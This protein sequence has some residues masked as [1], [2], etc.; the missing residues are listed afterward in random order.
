MKTKTILTTFLTLAAFSTALA[1]EVKVT[2]NAVSPTMTLTSKS[3]GDNI[4]TGSPQ[5]RAY[6]FNAPDGSYTLT[7]YGTDGTTVNGNIDIEINGSNTQFSVLT[8]TAYCTNRNA[9]NT[10]WSVAD[11]DYTFRVE[12]TTRDGEKVVQT[13]GNSVTAG[14]NTFLALNG[15]SYYAEFIPSK[16][17]SDE[18]YLTMTKG[19]TLTYNATVS[20]AMVKAAEV[21]VT[22]PEYAEIQLGTKKAHYVDFIIAEPS[23]T[24]TKN[25]SKVITYR[26]PENSVYNYRTWKE[27]GLT[28]GGYFTVS[29]DPAKQPDLTFTSEMYAT[30]NPKT[31][32]HDVNSNQGYETGDIFVN[33]NE[34]G[35]KDMNVGDVFKAHAMRT[36]ELTDNSTNNYFIEP[37]FHYTVVGLD[38]KP[39]TGVINVSQKPG[40]A[41]ADITAVGNGTAII[42]VTYDA[43][44]LNYFTSDG[45]KNEYLGGEFW[46][47]IW[48]ENTAAYVITVGQGESAAKP[49]MTIN[50]KYNLDTMKDAGKYV[51]A[52]HDVFYYLDTEEGYPYTFTAEGVADISIAYP[53]IGE[54]AAS[55]SGFG[56]E[57]AT[58]NG[59]G[60]YTVLL[61][62]GRQI[63]RLTDAAGKS[64]YQ[65]L[66]AKT[67]SREISN[68]TRPGSRIFQPGDEIKIQ[69]SGLRH[70]A[71][72]LAGIYNMSAYVTYNGIPNGTSLVLGKN[73][74]TF[75][76]AASA[77]AVKVTVPAD[78]D[79]TA[80][81]TFDLTEG[82]IQVNGYGDP[83]GNHRLINPETG[84]NANFTAVAHKTYFSAIPAVSIPLTAVRNFNIE[85]V[86]DTEGADIE[87]L[88]R[89]NPLQPG[90]DGLY[91]GTYGT[92][93]VVASKA[94]YRCFRHDYEI[95]ED[96]T[97]DLQKFDIAMVEAPGA[98]DGTTTKEPV[99]N[100][101]GFYIIESPEELAWYAAYVNEGNTASNA[102]LDSDIDLGDYL[103]TPVGTSSKNFAGTFNGCGHKV[104]GL[105]VNVSSNNAGLFGAVRGTAAAP[106]KITGITVYGSVKGTGYVGGIAG[107]LNDYASVDTCANYASVSGSDNF[108][109]GIAGR[110]YQANTS[111][112]NCYNAGQISSSGYHAGILGGYMNGRDHITNVFNVGEIEDNANAAAIS[113]MSG[114]KDNT[115]NAF[116][117]KDYAGT[118][119]YTVVTEQQMKSGEIAYKLGDAFGQKIGVDPYPVFGA[120]KVLYNEAEKLYYNEGGSSAIDSITDGTDGNAEPEVYYN[121]QGVK[122]E[123]PW[124]GINIVKMK[125]GSVRKVI[126][127]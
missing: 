64:T 123:T 30:R 98:W 78:L 86:C 88:Y 24:E 7:A 3:S 6:T 40:S 28:H 26:L 32:N 95:T 25:G 90:S 99:Q 46:G 29:S 45:K 47:A 21:T 4:E 63:V 53:T 108:V 18:G 85:L 5:S 34:R 93:T 52:E 51:D 49:E 37:D 57:G 73:Q 97:A 115:K 23:A 38:G 118:Q 48:P 122:S 76:S 56:S 27:G 101:A 19:G 82:V 13:P 94:G 58:D 110:T 87:L 89:G 8:C 100:G 109:G 77:Q 35:Y 70:P 84:R 14:R 80:Q 17:H 36:W 69:Y 54:H 104:S 44:N 96:A 106:A 66:T 42:L 1:T 67:C 114:A 79:V 72:K 71:N 126:V 116:A 2:M 113:G 119:D 22:I 125:D 102:R 11:G 59:D 62:E 20:G 10:T 91:T 16:E 81:P 43:I 39:S 111:I 15:C 105:Y 60:T 55:Y 83:I 31:V 12:V 61:K 41:W 117:I 50:E 75:G 107:Y 127:K 124:I 121:L 9:D 92:Y 103:W 74:Y 65:V 120:P 33:V 68:E 112:S